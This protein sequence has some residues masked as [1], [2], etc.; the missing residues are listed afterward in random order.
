[1]S[2]DRS[3]SEADYVRE[4]VE[5]L[6]S[7]R[8]PI[9]FQGHRVTGTYPETVLTLLFRVP[10]YSPCLYGVEDRIWE[11]DPITA[12]GVERAVTYTWLRIEE[13]VIAAETDLPTTC[14]PDEEGITHV[15]LW[16]G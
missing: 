7:G 14:Q 4:L 15:D 16:P 5:L 12:F 2:L 8:L 3:A 11:E 13:L 9:D 10:D 1:V 6:A